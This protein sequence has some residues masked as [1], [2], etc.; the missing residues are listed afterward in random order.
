MTTR[1]KKLQSSSKMSPRIFL[2][3]SVKSISTRLLPAELV[4]HMST[5]HG[6]EGNYEVMVFDLLGPSLE[7]LFE[8]CG[9]KFSLKTVL[10]ISNQLIYRLSYIYSKRIIHRDIKPDNILMGVGR[11]GNHVYI[12]DIG[13]A[14]QYL[15]VEKDYNPLRKP[16]FIGTASFVSVRGHIGVGKYIACISLIISN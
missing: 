2:G 14:T 1:V 12:A 11:L 9:R 3:L 13:I 16:I 4:F 10:M 7:D 6:D 15:S 5:W 8:F